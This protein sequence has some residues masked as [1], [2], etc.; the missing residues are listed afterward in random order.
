MHVLVLGILLG[1]LAYLARGS[2]RSAIAMLRRLARG[3]RI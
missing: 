1:T 3:Q 2:M